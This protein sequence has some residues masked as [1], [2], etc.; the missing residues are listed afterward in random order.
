M[1]ADVGTITISRNSDDTYT[2]RLDPTV[3]ADP[4]RCSMTATRTADDGLAIVPGTPCGS[5]TPSL[6][7]RSGALSVM[8][9]AVHGS[10]TYDDGGQ[11]VDQN[12]G[13][14]H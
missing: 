3:G 1:A 12:I 7:P 11:T 8:S 4:I 14:V 13:P 2:V 10:I 5:Q 9:G 6:T